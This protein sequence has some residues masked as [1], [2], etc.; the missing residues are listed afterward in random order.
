[1]E[2]HFNHCPRISRSVLQTSLHDSLLE[3][4]CHYGRRLIVQIFDMLAVTEVVTGPPEAVRDAVQET[5]GV[6][7][8]RSPVRACVI[9]RAQE[10]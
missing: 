6:A 5:P 3:K 10:A 9:R 4:S 1:M 2:A 8:V 7:T